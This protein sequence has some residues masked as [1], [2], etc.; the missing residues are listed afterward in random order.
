ML[1]LLEKRAVFKKQRVVIG[2]IN[3][4]IRPVLIVGGVDEGL[5]MIVIPFKEGVSVEDIQTNSVFFLLEF[6][7]IQSLNVNFVVSNMYYQISN[8]DYNEILDEINMRIIKKECVT[9]HKFKGL[10]GNIK[11]FRPSVIV[12]E[13]NDKILL[14]P[15][16]RTKRN[17][18]THILIKDEDY[19]NE[20]Q[21]PVGSV[22]L[23]DIR[24]VKK[25]LFMNK[26]IYQLNTDKRV[27]VRKSF[28]KLFQ[29]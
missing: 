22:M 3:G 27:V 11:G 9:W 8:F 29:I 18:E 20:K 1:S 2:K 28:D 17:I 25:E 15:I 12:G 10:K 19:K 14:V 13:I 6:N 23:D 4:F 24:L 5:H 26:K 21:P 16:T 7:E